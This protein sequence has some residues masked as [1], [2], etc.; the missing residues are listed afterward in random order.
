MSSV[1][2]AVVKSV[3]LSRTTNCL[4]MRVQEHQAESAERGV[5]AG[6]GQ[7]QTLRL[8]ALCRDLGEAELA[9]AGAHDLY[10]LGR[11]RDSLFRIDSEWLLIW[12]DPSGRFD[13][14]EIHT[15]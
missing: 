6:V 10:H 9:R 5:E 14:Y 3:F 11:E 12:L 2:P 8:P 4:I 15:D 1:I 7:V 13:R